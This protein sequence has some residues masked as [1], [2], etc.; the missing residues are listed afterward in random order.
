VKYFFPG[1]AGPEIIHFTHW[2]GALLTSYDIIGTRDTAVRRVMNRA[3]EF[4]N[5][6]HS[7]IAPV[8]TPEGI[9]G[10]FCGPTE[11][12]WTAAAELSSRRHIVYL[13]KPC[14]RILAVMPAMYHDL[15]T[16]AKGMYKAEPVAADGGEVVIH[17]PHITE[18]SLVHGR[19]IEQIGYHCRDYFVKQWEKFRGVPG[20]ILAHSTHVKGKGCY[21]AAS[22]VETPRIQVTLATGIS[23][24][25]CE[26]IN[27]GYMDPKAVDE[28]QFDLVIPRAGETL[29][30]LR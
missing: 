17:A 3:V 25:L 19:L 27:L 1:I 8:V 29:Y 18:V 6:P 26:R 5:R 28:T 13:D 7:L 2:L 4:L 9:A 11:E 20:G 15:W 12:A 24:E 23:R 14:R 30:R 16:G 21:D 22:K 10:V